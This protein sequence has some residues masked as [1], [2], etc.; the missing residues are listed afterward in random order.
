[1]E[2]T[3]SKW[4][5]APQNQ[6]DFFNQTLVNHPEVEKRQMFGYPCA[7]L[8]GNMFFGLFEDSVFLRLS[9]EDREEI[10]R[11]NLAT[12]F[13]PMPGKV[14]KEYVRLSPAAVQDE[15]MFLPWFERSRV[16]TAHLPVKVKKGSK[17]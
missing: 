4:K 16:F 3:Q 7:F 12:P 2:A 13:E 15:G 6:V 5:K 17:K 14:M 9:S 10:Q 1:M 11:E 8:G